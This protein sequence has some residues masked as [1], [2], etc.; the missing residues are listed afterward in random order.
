MPPIPAIIRRQVAE[1]MAA[2]GTEACY[3]L[4]QQRD[5]VTAKKLAPKD[6]QR[7]ARALEVSLTDGTSLSTYQKCP[8]QKLP[9]VVMAFGFSWPRTVLY[10][11]IAQRTQH[12]LA[13]GLLEE[14]RAIL[15]SGCSPDAP[16]L[17]SV[18]YRQAVACLKKDLPA[19]QLADTITRR[20]CQ[21][22]KR[23]LTWLRHHGFGNPEQPG[24]C[25]QSQRTLAT[26]WLS[27][28]ELADAITPGIKQALQQAHA[29]ISAR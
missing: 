12:M 9:A 17:R 23:Q 16:P 11:R 2:L 25:Y 5:P 7:I 26:C 28:S 15:N 27:T 14:T 10:Q 4:L 3:A 6:R 29:F 20:T 22:A 1:Q 8:P 19:E 18:G 13:K 21:L 24:R